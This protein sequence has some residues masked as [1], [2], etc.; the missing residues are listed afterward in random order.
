[1]AKIITK[2]LMRKNT[3]FL[4]SLSVIPSFLPGFIH[5]L[6]RTCT[7]LPI[8]ATGKAIIV[9]FFVLPN[10]NTPLVYRLFVIKQQFYDHEFNSCTENLKPMGD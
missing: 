8:S 4:F 10:A 7:H 1:M 3:P 9:C 5:T 6:R 2:L